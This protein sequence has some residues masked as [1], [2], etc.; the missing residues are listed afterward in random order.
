[1]RNE[2]TCPFRTFFVPT[3]AQRLIPINSNHGDTRPYYSSSRL[4]R[5]AAQKQIMV[6]RGN[7]EGTPHL[8]PQAYSAQRLCPGRQQPLY[9]ACQIRSVGSTE[10]S[11]ARF[12]A[13]R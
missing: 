4:T 12:Q 6:F 1:M 5:V 11:T 7:L 2:V 3:P 13:E 8:I 10:L 9:S